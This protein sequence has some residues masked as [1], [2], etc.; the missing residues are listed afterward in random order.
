MS[1][2]AAPFPIFFYQTLISPPFLLGTGR[3]GHWPRE[4]CQVFMP[5]PHFRSGS[6]LNLVLLCMHLP[7]APKTPQSF[8]LLCL[9]VIVAFKLQAI[10]ATSQDVFSI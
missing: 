5:P 9:F 1:Q 6:S 4:L 7:F 2:I 10:Y 3:L 8:L